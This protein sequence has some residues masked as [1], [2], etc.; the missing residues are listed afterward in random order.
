[1]NQEKYTIGNIITE[2]YRVEA[3]TE[4]FKNPVRL[5]KLAKIAV[6]EENIIYILEWIT[7]VDLVYYS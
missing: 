7:F 4:P 2:Q 3:Y 1:M 5:K 6:A